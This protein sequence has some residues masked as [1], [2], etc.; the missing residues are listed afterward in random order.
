[1]EDFAPKVANTPESNERPTIKTRYAP[2]NPLWR[3]LSF[4]IIHIF[5]RPAAKLYCYFRLRHTAKGRRRLRGYR[6]HGYFLY[7]NGATVKDGRMIAFALTTPRHTYAVVR[8]KVKNGRTVISTWRQLCGEIP[9]PASGEDA[10]AFLEAVEK[11]TVQKAAVIIYPE[12]PLPPSGIDPYSYPA[13]FDEPA[14]C[15]TTVKETDAGGKRR[16]VTYV[17]GPF[18]PKYGLSLTEQTED[19]RTRISG[20]MNAHLKTAPLGVPET[21]TKQS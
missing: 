8:P 14:F 1:M 3:L 6:R 5:L 17:D 18:Y 16:T 2:K 11:R 21:E 15:F 12:E 19:I 10:R 13:R 4:L 20:A 9:G 7:G